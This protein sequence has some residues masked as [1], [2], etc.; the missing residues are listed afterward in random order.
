MKKKPIRMDPLF[1]IVCKGGTVYCNKAG[2]R[3]HEDL[4]G[5]VK[6]LEDIN[7]CGEECFC[8]KDPHMIVRYVPDM[9][10]RKRHED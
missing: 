1:V 4:E 2:I 10:K 9:P 5:A 6:D 7:R 3:V 8:G